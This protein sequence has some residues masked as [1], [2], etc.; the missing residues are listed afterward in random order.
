M[1]NDLTNHGLRD[2]YAEAVAIA[3]VPT[4]LLVLV[5]LTN[6][7]R[8]LCDRYRPQREAGFGDNDG[9]GLSAEV[10]NEIR[11]SALK[12]LWEHRDAGVA[13]ASLSDA[14]LVEMLQFAMGEEIPAD[15]GPFMA[16]D[17]VQAGLL[18]RPDH[19]QAHPAGPSSTTAIIIG[20]GISGLCMGIAL[21]KAGVDY[22]VLERNDEIGGVW[23]ESTYP[24]AGVDTPNHLYSFAQYPHDWAH[25]F[26]HRDE[27]GDY[28]HTVAVVSGV[29]EKTQF[30]LAVVRAQYDETTHQ[31]HVIALD[32]KGLE[33]EFVA[34]L[35]ISAVGAFN[36][37]NLPEIKDLQ[38]FAGEAM[39]HASRWDHSVSL[40]GKRVT[41]VGVGATA[42]QAAPVI[43]RSVGQLSIIQRSPQ[44]I[45]P[46]EKFSTQVPEPVRFL[47]RT[48]REYQWWYRQRLGWNF[49]DRLQ[50]S[51]KIDPEWTNPERSVNAI[52]DR[53]RRVFV[54]YIND[55]LAGRPDLIEKSTPSY[56]PLGKRL[57]LDNGWFE[58]LKRDNVDLV[59]GEM[60]RVEGREVILSNGQRI[61]TDVLI[62]ATGYD[63]A[64]F[65]ATYEVV[66]R[67]GRTLRE[68][69]DDDDP[70]A[71][72]GSTVAGFP[73]LFMLYGPNTQAGH[74]GSII[75]ALEAQSRHVV[76]LVN[77][78][79]RRGACEVEVRPEVVK[80][81]NDEIDRQ[82]EH[83]I[84][85]HAGMSTYYRNSKGR[86]VI[87]IPFRNVE[88]WNRLMNDSVDNYR[89]DSGSAAQPCKAR[90]DPPPPRTNTHPSRGRDTA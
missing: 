56:P 45:A 89:F 21:A 12:V 68:A 54:R 23:N 11:A 5:H 73:N 16:D 10:Q 80:S 25:Y 27:I 38:E 87:P 48:S 39:F 42:M 52:N 22:T 41:F 34:D 31:W 64:R 17:M 7:R 76:A 78:M 79:Q 75:A 2:Q 51:L 33:R 43:A 57:L 26:A 63:V 28:L 81:Y 84:W 32:A 47:L 24:G 35:L 69:W 82:H 62:L 44:W 86:V 15:Y 29:R 36:R 6:D 61:D 55:Q 59:E 60:S 65:I 90:R 50:P 85:A 46:F 40:D 58:M 1:S 19:E 67:R 71:Y 3:N 72:L 53:H 88:L 30:S 9:G 66:G 14:E 20:A 70:R 83:M 74:G 49:N 4:L 77:E 37:P 13:P 18:A 8:W